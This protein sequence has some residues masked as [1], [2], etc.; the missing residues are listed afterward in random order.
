MGY[1]AQLTAQLYS[2]FIP[3]RLVLALLDATLVITQ[4]DPQAGNFT[5]YILSLAN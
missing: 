4:A 1:D 3:P 2:S 5:G